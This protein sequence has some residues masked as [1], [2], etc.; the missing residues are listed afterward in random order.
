MILLSYIFPREFLKFFLRKLVEILFY[1][2]P[3]EN[4][5]F[6]LQVWVFFV[7]ISIIFLLIHNIFTFVPCRK[8][9]FLKSNKGRQNSTSF[10]LNFFLRF[11]WNF[12]FSKFFHKKILIFLEIILK[13]SWKIPPLKKWSLKVVTTLSESDTELCIKMLKS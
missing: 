3:R 6:S 8:L 11:S 12:Y 1:I 4:K 5:M 10:F 13:F 2:F 7:R 9:I